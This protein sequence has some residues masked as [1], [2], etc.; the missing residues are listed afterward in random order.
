LSVLLHDPLIL[1]GSLCQRQHT[2]AVIVAL[3]HQPRIVVLV[4][5]LGDEP[6]QFQAADVACKLGALHRGL[7]FEHL[8]S[9]VVALAAAAGGVHR[10]QIT[11]ALQG[12]QP[13][14]ELAVSARLIRL[15][16]LLQSRFNCCQLKNRVAA[17]QE[18]ALL[19]LG[20]LLPGQ[21]AKVGA[22][23]APIT[24][25]L[26]V[27][28]V[29]GDQVALLAGQTGLLYGF[30]TVARLHPPGEKVP[31]RSG[32]GGLLPLLVEAAAYAVGRGLQNQLR[33]RRQRRLQPGQNVARISRPA[34][35][36]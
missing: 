32:L 14:R 18:A 24:D 35:Q 9:G 3:D 7:Q 4:R 26:E 30:G 31:H 2:A 22:D 36:L 12:R 23:A 27:Q 1:A 28:A 21:A 29:P 25:L 6:S 17:G 11:L 16:H 10:N 15:R 33:A 5:Q 19:A 34:R 8:G 13:D 20:I